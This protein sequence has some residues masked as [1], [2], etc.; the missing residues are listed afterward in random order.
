L[1]MKN[2]CF[3]SLNYNLRNN[4]AIEGV[5][6]NGKMLK[7]VSHELQNNIEVVYFA[8]KHNRSSFQYFSNEFKKK[9]CNYNNL[10]K[11][12]E[13]FLKE[14][15]LCFINLNL[16]LILFLNIYNEKCYNQFNIN[17]FI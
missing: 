17:K 7:Y 12:F 15:N 10:I 16:I 14:M 1:K 5:K 6:N 9:Y 2:N 4:I 8:V 13:I 11:I 3:K